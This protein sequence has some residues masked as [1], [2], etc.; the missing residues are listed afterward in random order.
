MVTRIPSTITEEGLE[1]IFLGFGVLNMRLVINKGGFAGVR[2][3]NYAYVTVAGNAEAVHAIEK[4]NMQPPLNLGVVLKPSE[5]EMLK[6][7]EQNLLNRAFY[8]PSEEEINKTRK[9]DLLDGAL[10]SPHEKDSDLE[11]KM[12][13][14]MSKEEV[15]IDEKLVEVQSFN[16]INKTRKQDLLD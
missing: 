6:I 4:L 10:N 1:N 3:L 12:N 2:G 15:L 7:R 9:Q 11:M 16:E 13:G 5:E 8:K 14:N